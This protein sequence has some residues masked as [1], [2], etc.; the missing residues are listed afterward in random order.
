MALKHCMLSIFVLFCLAMWGCEAQE[1]TSLI[2]SDP[3]QTSKES[4][5]E[6]NVSVRKHAS[7][8]KIVAFGDSLTAGFGVSPDQSYPAQLE[9]QL[10]ER[11][12]RYEVI[13]AGV[14]GETSAG[15]VRRVDWILKIQPAIVIVELGANDGLRGLP[16]E[17]TYKNLHTIIDRFQEEGIRVVLAG[18]RIPVNYGK[19]YTEEF[20]QMYVRL[21]QEFS[22]P[23]IPFFLEDVAA[24]PEFNQADGI[25][26]TA[27][28]YTIVTQNVLQTLQPILQEMENYIEET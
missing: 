20:F 9:K 18:M 19:E 21:A 11:G 26:P 16:L 1:D 17:Q 14:S 22:V 5:D 6:D 13:N 2:I 12:Y 24:Q 7:I 3:M 28:G 23:L 15:G 4:P 27:E 10:Q 8:Q 25:H